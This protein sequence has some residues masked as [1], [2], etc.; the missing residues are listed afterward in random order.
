MSPAGPAPI[1]R[2]SVCIVPVRSISGDALLFMVQSVHRHVIMKLNKA[3]LIELK[4]IH[5]I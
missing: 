2:R 3:I 1:T 4:L 5:G